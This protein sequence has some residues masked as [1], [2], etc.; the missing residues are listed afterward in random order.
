[1]HCNS[2]WKIWIC[3]GSYPSWCCN[4]LGT[5]YIKF[6]WNKEIHIVFLPQSFNLNHNTAL[7]STTLAHWYFHIHNDCI[8]NL[9]QSAKINWE[10]FSFNFSL[11][12][13]AQRRLQFTNTSSTNNAEPI[14][15]IV[16]QQLCVIIVSKSGPYWWIKSFGNPRTNIEW[17]AV[18]LSNFSGSVGSVIVPLIK[19]NFLFVFNE[20]STALSH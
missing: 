11:F 19:P 4:N 12:T 8:P 14:L 3:I 17:T 7:A 9:G 18:Q 20:V 6:H 15:Q 13:F 10:R 5:A 1:M 2:S 16:P